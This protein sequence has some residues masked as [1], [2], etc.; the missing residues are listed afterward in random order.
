MLEEDLGIM[1]C[2]IVINTT[3]RFAQYTL[4]PLLDS[5]HEAGFKRNEILVMSGGYSMRSRLLLNKNHMKLPYDGID[6]TAFAELARNDFRC[7]YYFIMHDTTK[8]GKDFKEILLSVDPSPWEVIALRNKPSMNIG[9]YHA[10]YLQEKSELI[11]KI[12]VTDYSLENM[13]SLK[14]WGVE[15]EDFLSWGQE[16][17]AISTYSDLLSCPINGTPLI[18]GEYDYYKNG[19][20][21]RVE[22]YKFLDL[23]KIKANW[24]RRNRYEMDL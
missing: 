4:P 20:I 14:V 11:D 1:K 19:V 10:H 17:V 5:L 2:K 9:M 15:N 3:K 8:V 18:L 13:H 21:R 7:D 6:Y 23:F 12:V 22:Y 16:Q 24:E